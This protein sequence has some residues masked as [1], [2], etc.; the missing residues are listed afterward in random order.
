MTK[1]EFI[2][3]IDLVLELLKKGDIDAVI[4]LLEKTRNESDKK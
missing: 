1:T 2:L 3:L 4:R